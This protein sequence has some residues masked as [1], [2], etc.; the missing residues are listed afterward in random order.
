MDRAVP[1]LPES[2][3]TP[4][5]W[6]SSPVVRAGL[7]S[8]D[9]RA[10]LNQ[11]KRS[12]AGTSGPNPRWVK[13]LKSLDCRQ[14]SGHL[15]DRGSASAPAFVSLNNRSE[16]GPDVVHAIFSSQNSDVGAPYI[17]HQPPG[18]NAPAYFYEVWN[19]C[20]PHTAEA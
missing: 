17:T 11:T 6:C 1:I 19:R 2:H 20:E 16:Y 9:I 12:Y 8:L 5:Q 18:K 4:H 7:R 14:E 13:V 15:S 3:G 10:S